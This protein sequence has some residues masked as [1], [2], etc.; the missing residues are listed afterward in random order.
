MRQQAGELGLEVVELGQHAV[1]GGLDSGHVVGGFVAGAGAD[2]GDASLGGLED[3][4]DLLGGGGG[5][6]R[7]ARV[8][9]CCVSK[10]S[11]TRRRWSSTAVMS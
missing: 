4:A 7:R 2:F 3:L 8:A 9:R 5:E 1:G 11:A 10:A 6:R